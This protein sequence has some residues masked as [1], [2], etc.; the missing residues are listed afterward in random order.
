MNKKQKYNKKPLSYSQQADL[1]LQRGLIA[2]RNELI[3][4]LKRINYYRLSG[5]LYYFRDGDKDFFQRGTTLEKILEI[6]N[7]DKEL[8]VVL[9]KYVEIIEIEF[10]T[11]VIYKVSKEY[12][13]FPL[14]NR[15]NFP[16]LD[17]Y[18]FTNL[19]LK[20]DNEIKK[21]KEIFI[22]HFLEK[23]DDYLNRPAFWMLGEILTFGQMITIFEGLKYKIKKEIS[24]KN[25]NL[26]R[27]EDLKI[28]MLSISVLRNSIAHHNR[29]WNKK[30]GVKPSKLNK[31]YHPEFY[32]PYEVEN[33]TLFGLI[34]MIQY[35]LKQSGVE[36]LL[37]DLKQLEL[38]YGFNLLKDCG[39][40]KDWEESEIWK[41]K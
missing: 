7:F 9:F 35:I 24:F 6:Y 25:Y 1:L 31:K 18:K 32:Y 5:Y 23:Y 11:K 37:N 17:Y 12:G 16:N 33:D 26:K 21:S 13:A 28:L 36:G 2:N 22:K 40:P 8:K 38:K 29:I 4:I 15:M 14:N 27:P 10:K 30:I 39:F 20:I 19:L 3:N 34:C 41:M